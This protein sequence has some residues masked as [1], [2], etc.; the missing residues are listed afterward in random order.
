MLYL[1]VMMMGLDILVMGSIFG[2]L[3][4]QIWLDRLGKILAVGR[5]DGLGIKGVLGISKI[6]SWTCQVFIDK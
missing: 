4:S 5:D 1:D 6:H 3:M 2:F